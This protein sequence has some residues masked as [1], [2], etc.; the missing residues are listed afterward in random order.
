[1]HVDSPDGRPG[2]YAGARGPRTAEPDGFGIDVTVVVPVHDE[3]MTV[4]PLYHQVAAVL[5]E[6][7]RTFEVVYVDDG[8]TDAS[9]A[10]ISQ[11]LSEREPARLVT[12]RR[13][14][15]KAA[16][17]ATGFR[18][19]RGRFVVTIDA[20]LQDDPQEIPELIL[21]LEHGYDA[22][23]GWKRRRQDPLRRRLASKL[24][25]AVTR[26]ASSL[27]L[28]DFNCG[29]KAYTRDC[30]QE[31]A[32]SCYGDMHRYLPVLAFWRGYRVTEK[33]V[34]HFPRGH[35]RS[36]YGLE[37]YVR[38][39]LDLVTAVFVTR[40]VRRP[41]H[42]FGSIGIALLLPSVGTLMYL[43]TDKAIAGAAIGGRPLLEISV[44]GC[45][46]GLQLV[47]TGLIAELLVGQHAS[48]VP[49]TEQVEIPVEVRLPGDA[50]TQ[51]AVP[52]HRPAPGWS[53]VSAHRVER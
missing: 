1:M 44:L 13:N 5:G 11:L 29:L 45:M 7:G 31:I 50:E 22:I 52:E 38:G 48:H 30:A 27:P 4:E 20:D 3:E 32:D 33:P 8:S 16:A 2:G 9:V 51:P 37:R 34:N 41:M 43:G 18:V 14:F 21:A 46:A 49:Y 47:L 23:S 17:L 6:A 26:R 10:K 53:L 36:K 42:F 19:A 35:G 40:Y 15:G 24:F 39:A 12:L 28:H 25:N